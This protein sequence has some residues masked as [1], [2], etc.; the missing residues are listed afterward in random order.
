MSRNRNILQGGQNVTQQ[1]NIEK[2]GTS[3]IYY[4][5]GIPHND[6]ISI[7][8][9]P[10]P[11]VFQET[12]TVPIVDKA[13]DYLMSVI[14]FQV[15]TS[16]IP[17]EIMPVTVNPN[18]STDPNYTIHSV[19]L[20]YNNLNYQTEL[21]WIPELKGQPVPPGPTVGEGPVRKNYYLY[22]SLYSVQWF[23]DMINTALA[24]SFT[25]LKTAN[26]GAP[27]TLPPFMTFNTQS[28]LFSLHAQVSYA[29]TNTISIFTNPSLSGHFDSSFN[30][31]Y[32]P[33][34]S[35]AGTHARYLITNTGN[36]TEVIIPPSIS[37]QGL[38][39]KTTSYVTGN[40]VY[41]TGTYWIATG[42]NT[43]DEPKPSSTNWNTYAGFTSYRMDQEFNTLP[44]WLSF[45]NLVFFSTA[46]GI[47]KEYTPLQSTNTAILQS[48]GDN[49]LPI[50]TDF[51]IDFESGFEIR[52][53]MTYY[54]TAQYKYIDLQSNSPLVNFDISVYWQDNYSNLYPLMIPAHAVL[55]MKILFVK[56]PVIEKM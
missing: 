8:G 26:P 53:T 32:Y 31:E 37:T 42:N 9:S 47:R 19:T 20:Q 41:W 14:R 16:R 55:T 34:N 38:W 17:I 46:A 44:S 51:I 49:Y 27:P 12:R 30:T 5:I 35:V 28:K 1:S 4:N 48:S 15:P 18:D 45:Q 3:H 23:V 36:N 21:I 6:L 11:A 50:L 25:A 43:N 29:G 2:V 39:N 22:Y 56:K 54:P 33:Y 10:T 40:I 52:N 24:T 13:S 7:N